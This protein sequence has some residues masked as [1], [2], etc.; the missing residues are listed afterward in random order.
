MCGERRVQGAKVNADCE[1]PMP[2][3]AGQYVDVLNDV[4]EPAPVCSH[5]CVF[6]QVV[7]AIEASDLSESD[8]RCPCQVYNTTHRD[9]AADGCARDIDEIG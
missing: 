6:M 8:A 2:V 9:G 5:T 4:V 7:L 1:M 3:S